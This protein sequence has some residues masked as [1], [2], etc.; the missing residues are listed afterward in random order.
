MTEKSPVKPIKNR[1]CQTMENT[2]VAICTHN[3]LEKKSFAV[4]IGNF[5]QGKITEYSCML[6]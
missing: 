1:T 4:L 2:E 6:R 5:Y 3:D